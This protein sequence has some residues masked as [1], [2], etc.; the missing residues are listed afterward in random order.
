MKT[1]SAVKENEF[2]L[3]VTNSFI[4]TVTLLVKKILTISFVAMEHAK[5][6]HVLQRNAKIK[7]IAH[8]ISRFVVMDIVLKRLVI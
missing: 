5:R 7:E 2:L 1:F 6:I 4:V 8:L 3:I